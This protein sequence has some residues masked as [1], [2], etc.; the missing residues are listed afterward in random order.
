MKNIG[1]RLVWAMPD[2]RRMWA[3]VEGVGE[4]VRREMVKLNSEVERN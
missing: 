3:M 1:K 2:T 4:K